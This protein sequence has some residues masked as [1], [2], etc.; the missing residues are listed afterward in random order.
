MSYLFEQL[1]EQY[2]N[3]IDEFQHVKNEG[4]N[5]SI[6]PGIIIPTTTLSR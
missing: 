3:L 1:T 5:F 6:S 4:G 2:N